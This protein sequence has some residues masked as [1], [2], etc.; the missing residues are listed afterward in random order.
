MKIVS[1]NCWCGKLYDPLIEF[2]KKNKDTIDIF[3]FQEIVFGGPDQFFS[4]HNLRGQLF[5]R[6]KDILRD[7]NAY[8]TSTQNSY[9]GGDDY[10]LTD[11]AEI[12]QA[13]FVKKHIPTSGD[14]SFLVYSKD[15]N[16]FRK[17]PRGNI[18]GKCQYVNVEINKNKITII[19]IHGLWQ[20]GKDDTP[21][22]LEQSKK[23]LELIEDQGNPAVIVGDFNFRPETKSAF[24][25]SQKLKNLIFDYKITKT[26]SKFYYDMEKYK[27]YIS[28][29]AF[30]S[31]EIDL[32]DFYILKDEVSDHFPLFLEFDLK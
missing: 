11:G 29:Y 28:D 31:S 2:I 30:I 18:T 15:N 13:I 24:I 8:K 17:T 25:L 14:N 3:C 5:D 10:L 27:D 16:P 23:I 20:S 4:Q 1:L 12:G 6:I 32:K 21:E 7:Y 26:R 22:R 19:N 9:Y